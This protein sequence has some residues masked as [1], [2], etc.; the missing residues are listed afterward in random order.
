VS[1]C[2]CVRARAREE[3]EIDAKE[4]RVEL[5]TLPAASDQD[6]RT[7]RLFQNCSCRSNYT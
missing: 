1:V 5:P 2:V 7:D 4:I 3:N 6:E